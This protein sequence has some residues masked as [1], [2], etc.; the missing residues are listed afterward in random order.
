METRSRPDFLC[1]PTKFYPTVIFLIG[2]A[3]CGKSTLVYRLSLDFNFLKEIHYIINLDPASFSTQYS[4]NI[5]IRDTIDFKKIMENYSLGPNGAILTS[6]NL[7]ATRFSQIKI[8][9]Q[10][11]IPK[12]K[13]ILLDTPGQIEIFTWSASGSILCETFSSVFPSI[14]LYLTD[15]ARTNNPLTFVSNVLYSCSILYKTRLP[16]AMVINKTDI[17]SMDFI[18]EWLND[19]E[20]FDEALSGENFFAGSFARSLALSLDNFHQKTPFFGTSA[21]SGKGAFQVL[22]FLKRIQTEFKITFQKE[23]EKN[24]LKFFHIL[25]K[26]EIDKQKKNWVRKKTIN[27][28]SKKKSI[29]SYSE[30]SDFFEVLEFLVFVQIENDKIHSV[31]QR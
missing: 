30:I 18:R 13:Y 9:I 28:D 27:A 26:N 7:F 2:M 1:Y 10:E 8:L 3:G 14:F 4:P 17:T 19:F 15:L 25:K 22:N 31:N 24:I 11:K 6:L 16:L 21:L 20:A 23:L 12:P 29:Y 5:D